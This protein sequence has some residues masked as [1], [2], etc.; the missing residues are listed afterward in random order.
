MSTPP[1][2]RCK[3]EDITCTER[4]ANWDTIKF[5]PIGRYSF[6]LAGSRIRRQQLLSFEIS[7]IILYN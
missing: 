6:H 5:R 7:T 1:L 3:T 4:C 2:N